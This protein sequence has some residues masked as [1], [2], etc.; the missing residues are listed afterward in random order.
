MFGVNDCL[1]KT[2]GLHKNI[3][4]L[5]VIH[6]KICEPDFLGWIDAT[7]TLPQKLP[8]DLGYA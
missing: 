2:N 1:L 3:E 8:A 4:A 7:F 5:I 6:K